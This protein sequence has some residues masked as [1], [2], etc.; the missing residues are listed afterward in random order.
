MYY[1]STGYRIFNVA[2]IVFLSIISIAC[3]LPL[4]HVLAISFSSGL[5]VDANKVTFWPVEFTIDSYKRTFA[6]SDF[7][8]SFINSLLRIVLGV[9]IG[10]IV[11]VLTAY[12]LSKM[13]KLKGGKPLAW[14]FVFTMLFSGGLIP[15]YIVIQKLHL[16]NTIW[17]IVLPNALGI[18]NMIL[19]L[20]FFRGIPKELEEA[21]LIDGAGHYATLFRIYVPVSM[22]SIATIVLFITITHWNAWFDALIY[23]KKEQWPMSTLLQT[24]VKA[25]DPSQHMTAEEAMMLTER[26]LKAAKLFVGTAPILL[27]Y[28]FLQRYFVKGMVLGAVKG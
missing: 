8:G 13:E 28:P 16:M 6:D 27:V 26:T 5:A 20:N 9:S 24:L 25:P 23:L 21:S 4:I 17:A 7:V 22:P 15:T 12:P 3:I 19:M 14:F 11:T 1:K 10:I 18:Y 2:N